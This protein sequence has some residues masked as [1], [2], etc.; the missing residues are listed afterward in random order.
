MYVLLCSLLGR[1]DPEGTAKLRQQQPKRTRS[2]DE[3]SGDL[4][5][6]LEL[7]HPRGVLVFPSP[8]LELLPAV[9]GVRLRSCQE[10]LPAVARFPHEVVPAGRIPGG[11]GMQIVRTAGHR[12]G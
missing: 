12:A 7:V 8:S 10:V 6:T 4:L 1:L 11:N 2:S 5:R 9:R 3:P